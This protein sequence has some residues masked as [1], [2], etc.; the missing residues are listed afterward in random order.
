MT[1]LRDLGTPDQYRYLSGLG[2]DPDDLG[3]LDLAAGTAPH[4]GFYVEAGSG[5]SRLL[6]EGDPI[7]AG[8]WISQRDLDNLAAGPGTREE[9]HGFGE[10]WGTQ[11]PQM[12]GDRS[13]PEEDSGG[14]RRVPHGDLEGSSA[15]PSGEN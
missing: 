1:L 8:R 15:D 13:Y 11:G 12:G 6:G 4:A 2:L 7:P 3:R 14:T 10:G 5:E 9:Q